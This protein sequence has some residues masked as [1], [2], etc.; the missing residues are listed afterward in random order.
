MQSESVPV[1][2]LTDSHWL[3]FDSW[4]SDGPI[5]GCHCGFRADRRSDYGW[6][7]SVVKHLFAVAFTEGNSLGY[8]EENPY[9]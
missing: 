7:D 8:I 6:G 3:L 9:E 5:A 4:P 2:D 1:S